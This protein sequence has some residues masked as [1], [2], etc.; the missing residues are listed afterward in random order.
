[1]TAATRAAVVALGVLAL[2][3]S[4]ASASRADPP[5]ATGWW[6][7]GNIEG[8]PVQAPP[9]DVPEGGLYVAGGPSGASGV[10]AL[11][12]TVPEGASL[13][14]LTLRVAAMSGTP[15]LGACPAAAPWSPAAGGSWGARPTPDCER[16][17]AP[18]RVD[19]SGDVVRFTLDALVAAGTI[20]IVIVPGRDPETGVD[21]SFE[22]S[23]DRP[24]GEALTYTPPARSPAPVAPVAPSP[25]PAP[26]RSTATTA[27]VPAPARPAYSAFPASPAPAPITAA[28]PFVPAANAGTVPVDPDAVSSPPFERPGSDP[29]EREG[30]VAGLVL[31]AAA[32]AAFVL[33]TRTAAGARLA[34]RRGVERGSVRGVG[35]YTAPRDTEPPTL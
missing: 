12:F 16:A 29:D 30:R 22:A 7:A 8:L 34:L 4:F 1:M 9:P 27:P 15:M 23:F 35:R 20:D 10:S 26:A 25:A 11:R 21:A 19:A 32:G 33:L 18:G 5:S 24:G 28:A 13:P 6:W 3:L 31:V 2:G 17:S 14:V